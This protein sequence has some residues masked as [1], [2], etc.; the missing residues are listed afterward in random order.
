[1]DRD[2]GKDMKRKVSGVVLYAMLF[3]LYLPAQAQQPAV[4]KIPRIGIVTGSSSESGSITKM[5]RQ[6]LQDLGYI[7]GKNILF[8]QRYT[9]GDR[10]RVPGIVAELMRLKVDILFSTQAIV[11]RA[12]KQATK[13]LP[14]VMAITPDPVATGLVDSLARPGGNITGVTRLT[15]ELSGKRLELLTEMIP[16][17]SRVGILSVAGLTAFKD[18]EDAAGGLGVSLQILEVRVPTPDLP[19][20]FQVAVKERV[21][22]IIVTSVPGLSGHR[23]QIVDL[24]IQN[25]LPLMSEAVIVAEAG[26]LASYDAKIDEIYRRAAIYV[27]KILKGTKPADLPVE[28]P[29]KF[30]FVINLKTAK[31]LNLTISQSVLFRA[32][33][34]IK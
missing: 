2:K 15:R 34:V 22:A 31:A 29:T 1:V 28:Q 21:N 20:A 25:R 7:E 4:A 16:R 6:A 27:D 11:V 18:Y 33:K 3:A 19:K 10:D 26:G 13:T 8:E 5:F 9:E 14:I 23:K 32:D 30:E 17:L 24:A 12:A